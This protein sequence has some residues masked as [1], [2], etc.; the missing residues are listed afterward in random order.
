VVRER[1]EGGVEVFQLL[2]D[3]RNRCSGERGPAAADEAGKHTHNPGRVMIKRVAA[4][5]SKM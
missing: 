5:D 3:S 4:V 2:V 1:E